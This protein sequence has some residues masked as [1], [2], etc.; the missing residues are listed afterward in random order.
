MSW[1]NPITVLPPLRPLSEWGDYAPFTTKLT[2]RW[3]LRYRWSSATCVLFHA[4]P[5]PPI[6]TL[7]EEGHVMKGRR[8]I[9][10]TSV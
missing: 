5:V 3:K 10:P 2:V 8:L 9:G 4:I 7:R 1:Y 6:P